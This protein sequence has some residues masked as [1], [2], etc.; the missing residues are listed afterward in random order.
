MNS[1]CFD[2][3]TTGLHPNGSDPDEILTISIIGRDGSVLLDERFRPTEKTEWPHASAI[4]GIYPEDVADLPAIET[5]IPRLREIFAGADEVI[6]YNVGFD[7]GFLSAVGVRPREDARITDTMNLFTW[8]MGRRY[9]LVD[10][11]DHIGYEWTGRAHGSL[12]DALATLAVQV[13]A[14]YVVILLSGLLVFWSA[15][16]IDSKGRKFSRQEDSRILRKHH[17]EIGKTMAIN[18]VTIMG[19]LTRDAELRKKGDATSVLTFGLAINEKKKD[20]ETGEYVDAPVFV[21][22]AL[23]GARAEALAPYLT[24]GKKVS[25]DGRLRYHSWMKNDEKRH[26]LS[27]LVTDI[28]FAD[29][30]GAGKDTVSAQGQSTEPET[31]DADIPF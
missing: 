6:G 3:E 2:T 19:N 13:C 14:I 7:L 21:D 18:R 17:R 4:N 9:K 20:S 8:F 28:E 16:F 27:V 15:I 25:V 5:A 1:I 22:C 10:A 29:S 26:A 30:K 23:F 31:Y 24:K 11:A 12:A